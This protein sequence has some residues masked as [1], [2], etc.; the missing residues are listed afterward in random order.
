MTI[1]ETN[2]TGMLKV[3]IVEDDE[4]SEILISIAVR[5]L[6]KE[7]FKAR[8]A[9]DAIEICRNN[10][11]IDLILMDVK[12]PEMDGY[13]AT[14]RIR[15]FNKSVYIIAQTAFGL[16]EEKEKAID[17]GCNDYMSKPLNI[18]LLKQMIKK[19]FNLNN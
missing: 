3:L 8:T 13:E 19:Q 14:S 9:I 17:S 12:L 16:I 15:Q 2:Q 5:K 18:A 11:D 10:P 4:T 7:I 6:C 1:E